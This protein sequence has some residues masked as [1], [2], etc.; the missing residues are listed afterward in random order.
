MGKSGSFCECTL[1]ANF[2]F[3]VVF[4]QVCIRR[5]QNIVKDSF[6]WFLFLRLLGDEGGMGWA[7]D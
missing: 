2:W 7:K 4:C 1:A 5:S 3:K 6:T